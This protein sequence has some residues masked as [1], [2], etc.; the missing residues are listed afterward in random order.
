MQKIVS[1]ANQKGGVGKTTSALNL[2]AGLAKRG[3]QVLCIDYDPHHHLT[4]FLDWQSDGLPTISTLMES[5]ARF[6][7][8]DI[9]TAL[10][11]HKEGFDYI[12]ADLDL[13]AADAY[14][15]SVMCRE[16]T[17]KRLLCVP[18]LGHYDYILID[19]GP[20]TG[21]LLTNAL[22]VSTGVIV[23]VQAQLASLSGLA[24][25]MRIIDMVRMNL[26]PGIKIM[27][28]LATMVDNTTMSNAV[29]EAL[30]T[31]YNE[32]VFHTGISRL[33]EAADATAERRSSIGNHRCRT[34]AE[35]MAVVD[36]LLAREG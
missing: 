1:I 28:V 8:V 16:Q 7:I 23:P 27:G 6:D 35:Y 29:C 25:L 19:C 31:D 30:F 5:T 17:L 36:E 26:N 34:G 13:S 15:V 9:G 32:L 21:L 20:S 3:K 22:T 11:R 33:I 12:P 10:R 14:L 18:A 24:E 4:N 2:A